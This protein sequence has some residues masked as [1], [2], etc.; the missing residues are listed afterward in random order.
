M[1][2]KVVHRFLRQP[3]LHSDIYNRVGNRYDPFKN[4]MTVLEDPQN[5]RTLHLI[6]TTNSSTTLAYRT[7]KLVEN[8]RP[9]FLYVQ[10]DTT[11]WN[12]AKNLEVSLEKLSSNLDSNSA[13]VEFVE[14]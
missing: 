3:N 11:W 14:G 4:T 12:F 10:A 7:K 6:G 9:D 13:R 8:L 1:S 2:T 5:N